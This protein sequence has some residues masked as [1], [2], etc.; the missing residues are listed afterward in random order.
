MRSSLALLLVPALAAA[1]PL[2]QVGQYQVKIAP[3]GE[4][5][6]NI[7]VHAHRLYVLGS[8]VEAF[9]PA[10]GKALEVDPKTAPDVG[11]DSFTVADP[12]GGAVFA[13]D[14]S[15]KPGVQRTDLATKKVTRL[16]LPARPDTALV[17]GGRLYI[18]IDGKSILRTDAKTLKVDRT[19][20]VK[21]C[22]IVELLAVTP[23]NRLV[24]MCNDA[25][26]V[27]D[28][29]GKQL[30][31][32]AIP[33]VRQALVDP[34]RNLL[35]LPSATGKLTVIEERSSDYATIQELAIPKAARAT[36]DDAGTLYLASPVPKGDKGI[37]QGALVITV[38][39]S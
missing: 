24:A 11:L 30:A 19:L 16:K 14:I 6:A 17:V 5:T 10:S 32:F 33:K 22:E 15:E 12:A 26:I 8:R 4:L 23:K 13:F 29:D 7:E 34:K 38:I 2:E 31:A 28:G 35:Y 20:T 1:S 27:I 36:L 37:A 25:T 21:G 9:D 3:G 39:G 18:V